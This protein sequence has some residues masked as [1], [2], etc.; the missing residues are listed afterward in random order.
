MNYKQCLKVKVK[1]T[2]LWLTLCNHGIVCKYANS[3]ME[4]TSWNSSGQNT[5]A[6][7]CSLLQG[8]FP[9]QGLSLSLLHFRWI[10]YQLNHQGSPRILEW[11]ACPFS[12]GS[13]WPGNWTRVSCVVAR[14]FTSWATRFSLY[15]L[16][17]IYKVVRYHIFW[18]F[19]LHADDHKF[20]KHSQLSTLSL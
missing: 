5:G 7:S 17:Y 1:L 6:G 2:Q 11:V 3:S 20:E 15:I 9:A 16:S 4:Y 10:L 12:R 14:F 13:S 8:I 18:S 19:K